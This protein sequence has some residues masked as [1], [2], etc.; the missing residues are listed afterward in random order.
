M[1]QKLSY[2]LLVLIL[3]GFLNLGVQSKFNNMDF[4]ENYEFHIS[5]S[6]EHSYR[7]IKGPS[8]VLNKDDKRPNII[9]IFADDMGYNDIFVMAAQQM[10]R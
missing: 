4:T 2:S 6:S 1:Y 9:L 5:N 10:D 3:S 8:E 7:L